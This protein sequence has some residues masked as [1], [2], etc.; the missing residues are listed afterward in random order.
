MTTTTQYS[1]ADSTLHRLVQIV[2]VAMMTGVDI[3]DPL[4]QIR[5]THSSEDPTQLVLTQEYDLQ[6]KAMI[7][8]LEKQADDIIAAAAVQN[9]PE[10]NAPDMPKLVLVK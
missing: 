9:A 1:M 5:L 3:A 4:R 6:F 8:K 2:Q 10:Q 7:R